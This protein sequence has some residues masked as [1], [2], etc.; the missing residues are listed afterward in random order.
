VSTGDGSQEPAL[1]AALEAERLRSSEWQRIAEDRRVRLERI[2]GHPL[3][4]AAIPAVRVARRGRWVLRRTGQRMRWSVVAPLVRIARSLFAAPRRA[5]AARRIGTAAAALDAAM[6]RTGTPGE[7]SARPSAADVTAVIVTRDQPVRLA[8]LL[9]AIAEAGVAAV[10]V[11]NA[12]SEATGAVLAA[13]PG[14]T[15]VTSTHVRYARANALGVE[16]VGTDWALLLNDDVEPVG[17][18]WL[19][20]LLDAATEDTVVVGAQLVHGPRGWLGGT[21]IDGTVQHDGIVLDASGPV[22]RPH[23][24]GRGSRPD[25]DRDPD[26]VLAVT[27]ACMLVRTLAW[28]AVGG[29]DDGYDFGAEDVDLCVRVAAH[30]RVRVAHR[31]V[32]LHHEGAT[33]LTDDPSVRAARQTANWR[34][35]DGLHAAALHRAARL[36]RF[37][38]TGRVAV[39]RLAVRRVGGDRAVAALL[40]EAL[41]QARWVPAAARSSVARWWDV[42][43]GASRRA[44]V[45]L[46]VVADPAARLAAWAVDGPASPPRVLWIAGPD[47]VATWTTSGWL[48]V[49]DLAVV[50]DVD[51]AAAVRRA[52]PT[53]PTT[54]VAGPDAAPALRAAIRAL[55]AAPRWS[56]RIGAPDRRAAGRWGDTPVAEALAAELRVHGIVT[57]VTTRD[58]WGCGEDAVAE[59]AV[60]LKGRGIAPAA[61]GRLDVVWV[62]SHPSEVAPEELDA[63]DLVLAGSVALAEDL[64]TRTATPVGVLPQG[65]DGRRFVPGAPDPALASR[66]LFVGNT[67]SEPRPSVLACVRAGLP[68]TLVGRG[69]ERF[70][71][72]S[73]VRAPWVDP[74]ALAAWYRSAD[75]VLND[76]WDDMRRWGL[77]SNRV[78]EVLASGG[79]IV[80]DDVAGLADLVGDAV[81]TYRDADELVTL[82][83]ALL[84]DPARRHELAARGGARVRAE[85]LLE[86]RAAALVEAVA[87]VATGP[88][89]RSPGSTPVAGAGGG[90]SVAG[91]R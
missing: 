38:G 34:R 11:E 76:H 16:R 32:L 66:V 57:R 9:D 49:G 36:D 62:M 40:A 28:Q 8:R 61:P 12:A 65:A 31:A 45:D 18:H 20:A 27:G 84:D 88:D 19:D 5:T 43:T 86:H 51:V 21:A 79:C 53:I 6:V 23:H 81:P 39:G 26:D 44:R 67:R 37:D 78:L 54:V 55:L 35:F 69:W 80:S 89:H 10:V 17:R 83:R 30:G 47:D 3:V 1:R 29:M 85:H 56:L 14:V 63:V 4:R 82:V 91:T 22:P 15:R 52:D 58:R 46:L 73:L 60:H 74:R 48:A 77:V 75:V 50:P 41:P 87:R 68:V 59:V 90:P 42:W 72:P 2:V 33:R 13:R 64:A 24:L 70:V 71:D 25:V 7:P